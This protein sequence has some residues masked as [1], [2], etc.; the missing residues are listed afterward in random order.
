MASDTGASNSFTLNVGGV[1]ANTKTLATS[2]VDTSTD[3]ITLTGHGF[4]TGDVLT[5]DANGGTAIAG[6]TDAVAYH[7]IRVDDNTF[8]LA[9]SASNAS[10][11]TAIDITGAGNNSQTFTSESIGTISTVATSAVTISPTVATTAV[12][13][14]DDRLHSVATAIRPAMLLASRAIWN[15][16]CGSNGRS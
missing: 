1:G 4:V 2:G 12:S 11:G 6:L 5:Y 9:T 13:T 15:S 14:T 7:V 10:G 8:S 16:D 3:R